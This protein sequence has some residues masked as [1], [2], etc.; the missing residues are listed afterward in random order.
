MT[1]SYGIPPLLHVSGGAR[2][3]VLKR[4]EFSF[5]NGG[6]LG[7]VYFDFRLNYMCV[8]VGR[9]KVFYRSCSSIMGHVHATWLIS[10]KDVYSSY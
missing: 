7:I 4:W 10:A 3:M 8:V 2:R 1:S 6:D 5:G 9:L